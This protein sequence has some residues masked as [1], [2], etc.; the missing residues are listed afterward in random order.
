M[1]VEKSLLPEVLQLIKRSMKERD[2]T[3]HQLASQLKM[4]ESG[5][6]K[7]FRAQDCSFN[8]LVEIAETLGLSLSDILEE[9]QSTPPVTLAFDPESDRFLSENFD[10]F[11]VYWQLFY[12]RMSV[13]EIQKADQFSKKDLFKYLRKL[14]E[15]KLIELHEGN[16]VKLPRATFGY[17]K[18]SKLLQKMKSEWCKKAFEDAASATFSEKRFFTFYYLRLSDDSFKRLT[19]ASQE[20]IQTYTRETVRNINSK[21]KNTRDYRMISC[22][23]AGSFVKKS[24]G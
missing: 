19:E 8:R 7:V 10:Y 18:N 17:F 21:R 16:R 12:E 5:L 4:S 6:K 20:L 23:A 9:I 24:V 15:L 3:Y 1:N 14:D 2:I 22:I 11:R 13:D